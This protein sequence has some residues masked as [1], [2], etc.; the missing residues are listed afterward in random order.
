MAVKEIPLASHYLGSGVEELRNVSAWKR[1]GTVTGSEGVYWYNSLAGSKRLEFSEGGSQTVR[2]PRLDYDESVVGLWGFNPTTTR[3]PFTL[4]ANAQSQLV[5]GLNADLLDGFHTA[6]A[7]DASTVARRGTGGV[8]KVANPVDATDAVNLQT[9][10]S[11]LTTASFSASQI[12]SGLLALARGGTNADLSAVATGGLVYK[13][14][15]ALA[16]TGALT[17]V[18]IG[19]GASAPTAV[20]PLTITNGGVGATTYATAR[21]NL[22][23]PWIDDERGLL[24]VRAPRSGLR[25]TGSTGF[26]DFIGTTGINHGTGDFT[27]SFV[28]SADDWTPASSQTLLLSHRSGQNYWQ[29]YLSTAGNFVIRAD[30]AGTPT[31]YTMTPDVALVNGRTYH[32]VVTFDRDGVATLYVNGISDRDKNSTG[33][34]ISISG[35]STLNIGSGNSNVYRVGYAWTGVIYSVQVFSQLLTAAEALSLTEGLYTNFTT[36]LDLALDDADPA[37]STSVKDRSSSN[38]HATSITSITQV[39]PRKQ[40]NAEGYLASGLTANTIVYAGTGGLLT[41]LALNTG[42]ARF[43]TQ[44]SSAAPAWTDLFGGT[45]TWTGNQTFNGTVTV[46]TPTTSGHAA[47]KAYVDSAVSSGLRVL[48]SCACATTAN[49]TLSGEQTIDG[50]TTSASRVLVKNQSTSS[51]NGIYV[52]AAGAWSR[53]TDCDAASEITVGA[54][55][56]VTGGTTQAGTSW[57]QTLTV[58]TIDTDAVTWQLFFQQAAYV[59]GTGINITGLT[60]SVDVT[61]GLDWTGLQTFTNSSGVQLKPHGASAGNTTAIRFLELAA[62]GTSSV[63]FKAADSLAGDVTWVLPSADGSA[64]HYLKTNGS[65][66]LSF[67]QISSSEINNTTFVTGV[68]GTTNRISVTG[69]LA[70]SVDID[71]AYVGQASITT[72]GTITTGTWNGTAVGVVYGGTGLTSVATG[73]LLYASGANTLA[74][75]TITSSTNKMLQSSGTIPTWSA[76]TM[77]ATVAANQLLYASSTTAV[78]ALASA[79][80]SI[81]TTDASQAVGW[82]TSLPTG[83]GVVGFTG[84][85][86]GKVIIVAGVGDGAT[87]NVVVTHNFNTYNVAVQVWQAAG[88]RANVTVDVRRT[89]ANA[90]TLGFVTA[91][92][93]GEYDVMVIGEI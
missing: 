50:V 58:T 75:L 64:N 90:V 48:A 7:A 85:K 88:D 23:V 93:V 4:N 81:L 51:Q 12:T 62:N 70:P 72:L 26:S 69:T 24:S 27:W 3:A 63:G 1:S 25:F 28:V 76:Y 92:G 49:I 55:T 40:I 61:D 29:L 17:G 31:D 54:Y 37:K 83:L 74:R 68:S 36:I 47:T 67:A 16:G 8:L 43:L 59:G 41:G 65:G 71:A 35:H 45:N 53:A 13:A 21:T 84:A 33:V 10:T 77:P 79:A 9:L 60:L 32:V 20:T 39:R 6:E 38:N 80:S 14:A 2:V 91:P 22:D 66:V 19:N 82:R 30:A 44:T 78:T 56:F 5:T 46:G 87:E 86:V 52:S 73:D 34:T 42:G 57:S 18:L 11:T 15:S 89:S